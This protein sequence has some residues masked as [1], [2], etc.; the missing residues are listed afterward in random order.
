MKKVIVF[1]FALTLCLAAMAQPG[2]KPAAAATK[3]N[4]HLKVFYQ[5]VQTGDINSAVLALNYFIAE[6]P[7]TSYTDTLA[8]LYM[9]QGAYAQC[10][11]WADK[12]LALNPEDATL[13]EMKAV[14]L[15][16]LQQPTESITIF[17]KLFK[18]T[19]SPFHAYKLMELQYSIKR[20]IECVATADAAERLQYKPEYV[21]PYVVGEQRGRTYLQAGV[22]N[23]HALALYDLDRKAE[24]KKYFEKAL[25]LDSSFLLAKQNLEAIKAIEAGAGKQ[26]AAPTQAAGAP[27]ANKQ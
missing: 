23:V 25:A 13:M 3:S 10:Y 4:P 14:C 2:K 19:Q 16:K 26:G 11:Y 24:A 17:E 21:M 12:R 8:M 27:P 5:A 1:V 6:Q 18:K 9:Q 20:L 15:D 7:G 22:Y